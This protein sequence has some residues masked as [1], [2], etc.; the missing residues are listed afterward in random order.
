MRRGRRRAPASPPPRAARSRPP[1]PPRRRPPA[2]V[3]SADDSSRGPASSPSTRCP[4]RDEARR[5]RA[6]AAVGHGEPG[7]VL[8][9]GRRRAARRHAAGHLELPAG[10]HRL[11]CVPPSGKRARPRTST[12]PRARPRTTASRSRMMTAA[13]VATRAPTAQRAIADA[14]LRRD[15][16]ATPSRPVSPACDCESAARRS[17]RRTASGED[18]EACSP[19]PPRLHVYRSLVRNGLSASVVAAD[20]AAHARAARTRRAPGA[21]T[22]ISRGS[23]DDGGPAHALP[24]RRARASSSRG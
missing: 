5:P 21:S 18:V 16:R 11:D 22:R 12:S 9:V 3:A 19:R 2:D 6:T 10:G 23:R 20:A 1:R 7:L 13:L 15:A 17:S 8:G 4:S 24:A 14:C